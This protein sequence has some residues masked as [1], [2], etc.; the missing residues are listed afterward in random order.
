MRYLKI[1]FIFCSLQTINSLIWADENLSFEYDICVYRNDDTSGYME[2]Y[3]SFLQNELRVTKNNNNFEMVGAI[4]LD[5][6]SYDG[7]KIVSQTFRTPA[8]IGDTANYNLNSKLLGQI[9]IILKKGSYKLAIKA[10]D[11]YDTSKYFIAADNIQI[12][13]FDGK[14]TSS[15]LQLASNITKSQNVNDVFYKNSLEVTPNPSRLFGKNFSEVYYYIEFYNMLPKFISGNYSILKVITDSDNNTVKAGKNSY[16]VKNE[17][18][19]EYGHF[20]ISDLKTGNYYLEVVLMDADSNKITQQKNKFW[21]YNDIDTSNTTIDDNEAYAIS[22]YKDY[23]DEQLNLEINYI[24]YIINDKFKSQLENTG[25]IETK[26]R[27][28][29]NFW[30]KYD[31]NKTTTKNEFKIAYFD[32]IKYANKHFSSP[33]IEGWK[34]DRGRVYA[35]YGK[36]DDVERHP[37]EPDSKAYEIWKYDNLQGGVEF[38]FIDISSNGDDYRL[39]HSTMINEIRDDSWRNRL[40][41]SK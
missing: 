7:R 34:T 23:T 1:L 10:Y 27:L 4:D 19:V 6:S 2:L 37:F 35:L 36:P 17:S 8:L 39:V 21:V 32:K 9:N 13:N 33:F 31:P 28:L 5:I 14:V 24:S 26:R 38:V 20:N 11:F 3:Y 41:V 30:T 29:F 40:K 25:D 15:S 16:Q 12:D 22:E 18:K